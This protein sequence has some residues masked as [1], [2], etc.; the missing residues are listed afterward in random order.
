MAALDAAAVTDHDHWGMRFMDGEPSI[1]RRT[2]DAADALNDPGRFV[3]LAGY[4]WTNWV[5][6][7]RHV[8]FF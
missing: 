2:L 3:A 7:H 8:V 5:E 4:E 1:W 6:G